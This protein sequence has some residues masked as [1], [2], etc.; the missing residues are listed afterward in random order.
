M[1]DEG[2]DLRTPQDLAKAVLVLLVVA[3][4]IFAIAAVSYAVVEML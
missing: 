3:L 1:T 2:P 4:G